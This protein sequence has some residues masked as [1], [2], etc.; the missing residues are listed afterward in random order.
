MQN[1]LRAP[2]E[3]SVECMGVAVGDTIEAGD[4]LVVIH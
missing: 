1:E 4:L 3:G 2:C